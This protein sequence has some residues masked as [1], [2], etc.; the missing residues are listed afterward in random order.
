[1]II[2]PQEQMNYLSYNDYIPQE[3][4]NYMSYND[5][6]PQEQMN[7]MSY[8]DYIPPGADELHVLQWEVGR[9]VSRLL[10]IWTL[11]VSSAVHCQ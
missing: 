7:Y 8:N 11:R 2:Y 9:L 3:Q 1:M 5:Y 4:I 6:I 10:V